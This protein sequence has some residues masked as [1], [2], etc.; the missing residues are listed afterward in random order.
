VDQRVAKLKHILGDEAAAQKLVDA[1]LDLPRK[2]KKATR[3]EL[4]KVLGR[5]KAGKVSA[6]L[7][8]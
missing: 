5:S 2:I 1:G 4:D 3:R 6:R 7:G 8:K